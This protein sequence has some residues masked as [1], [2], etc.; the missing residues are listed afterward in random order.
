MTQSEKQRA[1]ASADRLGVAKPNADLARTP[2][3][4]LALYILSLSL[5]ERRA[6]ASELHES[7]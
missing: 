2:L 5:E 3:T 7:L 4:K 6:R 1:Q